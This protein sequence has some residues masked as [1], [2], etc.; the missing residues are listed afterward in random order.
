MVD[1][2]IPK[3]CRDCDS[4]TPI[5]KAPT[6]DYPFYSDGGVGCVI[7]HHRQIADKLNFDMG[8]TKRP[9]W[10]PLVHGEDL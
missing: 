4:M 7:A 1:K 10:C 9:D 2:R 5:V 3:D 6:Q 8:K